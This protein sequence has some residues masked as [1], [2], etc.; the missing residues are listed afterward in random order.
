DLLDK[1][2]GNGEVPLVSGGFS[3]RQGEPMRPSVAASGGINHNSP[4]GSMPMQNNPSPRPSNPYSRVRDAAY[5]Q[6]LAYLKMEP[7]L[8]SW[9]NVLGM[10]NGKNNRGA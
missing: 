1:L 7:Q 10:I 8:M 4:F 5:K 3:Q 2:M 6:A 9:P